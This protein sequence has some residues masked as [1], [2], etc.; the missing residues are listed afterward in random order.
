MLLKELMDIEFKHQLKLIENQ[1]SL[2]IEEYHFLKLI[3]DILNE[4]SE[5]FIQYE[6]TYERKHFK[7]EETFYSGRTDIIFYHSYQ[8]INH[9][10]FYY[11][12]HGEKQIDNINLINELKKSIKLIKEIALK[13]IIDNE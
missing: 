1:E 3:D 9:F 11:S 5:D 7:I 10:S 4:Q 8:I 2:I 12:I 6:I 13:K